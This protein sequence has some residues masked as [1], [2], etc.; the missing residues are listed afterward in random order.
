MTVDK[1][2][3]RVGGVREPVLSDA[4]ADSLLELLRFRHFTRYYFAF[5]YD[6][7]KLDFLLKKYGDAKA[8]VRGEI[9]RFDEFLARIERELIV[10]ALDRA[11]GN[12][13]KAA[14]LLGMSRPRL[15]R[16]LVQLGLET[17]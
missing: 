4:T 8:C 17:Q 13:A 5:D 7:D 2:Q 12:K 3:L 16:R 1:M 14:R 10:R 9:M 11:K 6:W 15:Y